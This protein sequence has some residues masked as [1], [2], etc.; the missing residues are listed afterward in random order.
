[1][2]G[3]EKKGAKA[4][5]D[6]WDVLVRIGSTGDGEAQWA[7]TVTSGQLQRRDSRILLSYAECL[8]EDGRDPGDTTQVKLL[9]EAGRVIMRRDGAFTVAM[10]LDPSAPYEGTYHTPYGDLRFML[11][12]ELCEVSQAG[13]SG[14]IALRYGLAFGGAEPADRLMRITWEERKPC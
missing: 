9:A 11:T 13:T 12:T 5:P 3:N 4:M 10:V 7:E 1:M 2:M 8:T 6:S 14:C